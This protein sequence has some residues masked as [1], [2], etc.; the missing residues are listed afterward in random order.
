MSG[1]DR[2]GRGGG[3]DRGRP[4]RAR[5][6]RPR[7]RPSV[8]RR[9]S[10]RAGR[11]RPGRRGARRRRTRRRVRRTDAHRTDRVRLG[12]ARRDG[13]DARRPLRL[14][15]L[16]GARRL[17]RRGARDQRLAAT[18]SSTCCSRAPRRGS[19]HDIAEQFDAVGGDVNAFT[20]K[21]YTCYYARV[22]DRDLE[23]AVD[24]LADMLQHSPDPR[25]GPRRR[26]PGDPRGDQHARGLARGRRARPLHRDAVAEPPARPADPGHASR[27]SATRRPAR[28][29]RFYRRHYV[30]GHFVVA[31]AGNVRHDDLVRMLERPHG[32]RAASSR[33]GRPVRR[34]TSARAGTAA[35]GRRASDLVKRRKT[36]QAHICLGTNGLARTDPDRFAFLIVNTALGGGMSSRLF[37]EIR[38]KRGLAYS[39]T[40]TTRSTRRRAC[41]PPTPARRRAGRSEV[42]GAAPAR[43]R[44]RRATAGS[45][46]RSSNGRRVT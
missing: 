45:P 18:S 41:S 42:V 23:M 31:A 32:H 34:G 15:R 21:E 11:R 19:A 7:P 12:P 37:Q 8:P 39:C 14:A 44:G 40:A 25:G 27:R 28:V 30:P 35:A 4:W 20:A 36:E 9:S 22:L 26:A 33:H 3:R 2:G 10:E 5:G 46:R 16:L 17:A 29:Q 43:A 13:A 1:G 24:H 6:P 38:E